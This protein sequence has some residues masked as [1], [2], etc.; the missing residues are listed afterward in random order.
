MLTGLT[1]GQS[2]F[3]VYFELLSTA[4]IWLLVLLVIV[5]SLAPDLV[6]KVLDDTE[7]L[8]KLC[9]CSR[10]LSNK[11]HTNRNDFFEMNRTAKVKL[12]L[13]ISLSPVL[14]FGLFFNLINY[15]GHFGP[16]CSKRAENWR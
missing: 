16:G 8:D 1:D 14:L 11:V 5:A 4:K 13:S 2:Y 7:L 10:S 12:H 3:G 15:L 6:I 9:S